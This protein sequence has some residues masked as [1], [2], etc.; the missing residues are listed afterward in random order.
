MTEP[1][2]IEVDLEVRYA[3]TDQMGV[4]HHRHHIVWF[5][6]ARTHLCRATGVSYPEI[7]NLGYYLM[8]SGVEVR[9]RAAVRYG[10]RVRVTAWVAELASR[11]L[12]FDYQVHVE[13]RL[14][15][16]GRTEHLWVRRSDMR[17][18][19]IPEAVRP[20][21]VRVAGSAARQGL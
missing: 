20:G 12:A 17:P 5:E 21:F 7:E 2:R 13:G 6:L 15:A 11:S 4:V 18:V 10:E 1:L 14:C 8:L 9:Y 3:E 19:R 16:T